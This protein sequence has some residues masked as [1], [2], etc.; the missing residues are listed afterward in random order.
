MAW[1][2]IV[3]KSS[4]VNVITSYIMFIANT[5][6]FEK[7]EILFGQPY[8]EMEDHRKNYVRKFMDS[9][10]DVVRLWRMLDDKNRQKLVDAAIDRYGR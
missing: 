1:E 2:D 7:V 10:N 9:S 5:D 3:R 8:E 4:D 6:A